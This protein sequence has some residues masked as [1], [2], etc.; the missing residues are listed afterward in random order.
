MTQF[1]ETMLIWYIKLWPLL[2][3]AHLYHYLSCLSSKNSNFF[4][5]FS[6]VSDLSHRMSNFQ[7]I[8]WCRVVSDL[9]PTLG[10]IRHRWL[11][12]KKWYPW[13]QSQWFKLCNQRS[14]NSYKLFC[15]KNSQKTLLSI[16]N[17]DLFGIKCPILPL[18]TVIMI[19]LT[20]VCIERNA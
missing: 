2:Y 12:K 1:Y 14:H 7:F 4:L 15:K 5:Q 11:K 17:L 10:K 6:L 18:F 9:S 20:K 16:F 19:Y 8:S 13:W 3:V